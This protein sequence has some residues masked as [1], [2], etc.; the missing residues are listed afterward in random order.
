MAI[1]LPLHRLL[2]A[3]LNL[4]EELRVACGQGSNTIVLDDSKKKGWTYTYTLKIV[5]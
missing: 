4:T 1:R 3:A 5:N 2:R